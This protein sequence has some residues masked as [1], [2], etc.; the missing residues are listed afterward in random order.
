MFTTVL[1][2]NYSDKTKIADNTTVK[3]KVLVQILNVSFKQRFSELRP[4]FIDVPCTL[5]SNSKIYWNCL[6]ETLVSKSCCKMIF[7]IQGKSLFHNYVK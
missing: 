6:H 4:K 7:K 5:L 2:N 3:F 1:L